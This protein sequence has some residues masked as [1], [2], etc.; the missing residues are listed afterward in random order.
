[1][2]DAMENR[3]WMSRREAGR[4]LGL[5][6]RQLQALVRAGLLAPA[7]D[8]SFSRNALDWLIVETC[9]K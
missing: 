5:D 4:I 9:C 2:E 1:M 3:T 7:A 6:G 8:G